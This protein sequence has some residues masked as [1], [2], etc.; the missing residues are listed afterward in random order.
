MGANG[1]R[2]R[3]VLHARR[4][5][6]PATRSWPTGRNPAAWD[7]P[8]SQVS[9]RL[10]NPDGHCLPAHRPRPED[11]A[12]LPAD[13]QVRSRAMADVAVPGNIAVGFR[14]VRS[15][16]RRRRRHSWLSTMASLEAWNGNWGERTGG[17]E[18]IN[19]TATLDDLGPEGDLELPRERQGVP[20]LGSAPVWSA[21]SPPGSTVSGTRSG[22]PSL[23]R[24]TSDGD[25]APRLS[26]RCSTKFGTS[27]PT[28]D[29][30]TSERGVD[31]RQK[32]I[33][34]RG[35]PPIGQLDD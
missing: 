26:L 31:R 1:P 6:A 19:S 35:E 13:L 7:C 14:S 9:V 21:C 29:F 12:N 2:G 24:A 8:R 11:A 27:R 4:C 16:P 20:Q 32:T 22:M 34:A 23:S 17:N 28:T 3:A 15:W 5:R 25:D 30:V 10:R 33:D 18:A